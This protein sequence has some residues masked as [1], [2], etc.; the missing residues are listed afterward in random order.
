MYTNIVAQPTHGPVSRGACPERSEG[1]EMMRVTDNSDH[2]MGYPL[3]TRHC[4]SA[5]VHDLA[6]RW[7]T[8]VYQ[9]DFSLRSK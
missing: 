1:L 3:G 4:S 8:D 7:F 6:E 9:A 5:G 2:V